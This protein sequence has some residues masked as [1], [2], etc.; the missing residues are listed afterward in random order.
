VVQVVGVEDVA[1]TDPRDERIAE[2]EAEVDGLRA[3]MENRATIEQAKG[4][5]MAA[6]ACSPDEAF[7]WLCGVSQRTNRK[8]RDLARELVTDAARGDARLWEY[9]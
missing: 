7:E 6:R 2:L 4:L 5:I 9:D 3:A 1:G 8:L